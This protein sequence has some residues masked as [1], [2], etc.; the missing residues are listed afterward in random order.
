MPTLRSTLLSTLLFAGTVTAGHAQ[1]VPRLSSSQY[2]QHLLDQKTSTRG[3]FA[4]VEM[5]PLYVVD[6]TPVTQ[7]QLDAISPSQI[8]KINIA[9]DSL[10]R[11]AY[12]PRAKNGV[13]FITMKK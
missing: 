3:P 4:P 13:V 7:T 12:G 9:K 2:V 6:G 10:S 5:P 8:E 11:A 1:G